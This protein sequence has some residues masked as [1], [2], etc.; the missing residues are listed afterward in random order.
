VQSSRPV[1]EHSHTTH[2]RHP[3]E[4][5]LY[6]HG[7][8]RRRCG[9]DGPGGG[10]GAGAEGLHA[11]PARRPPAHPFRNRY[12]GRSDSPPPSPTGNN[13]ICQRRSCV[14]QATYGISPPPASCA[15]TGVLCR[16]QVQRDED[17]ASGAPF[18]LLLL[19]QQVS[20]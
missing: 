9:A 11:P 7:E 16:A 20:V 2:E 15:S 17:G 10:D 4:R 3:S 13:P 19:F 14:R 6:W 1:P 5:A 8:R 18:R 12:P